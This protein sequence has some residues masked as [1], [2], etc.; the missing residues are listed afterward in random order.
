MASNFDVNVVQGDTLKWAMYLKDSGGTAYNLG[1]CTLG[2]QVR[3]SY[4]PTS[5]VAS[6]RIY[7]PV[8]STFADFPQGFTGGLAASATGGTIYIA[9]GSTYTGQL[10]SEATAKYDIQLTNPRGSDT[11]TILRGSLTVLPEVTR[12]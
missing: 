4:Y 2:M 8:G 6:Y 7:V 10:S 1:G 12:F 5:V 11:T 3:K 9:I